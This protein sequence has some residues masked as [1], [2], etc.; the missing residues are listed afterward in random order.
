MRN[1]LKQDQ[2]GFTI[3]EVMIVLA[4]AGL[5]MLVVFMAVPAL[6]R[7]SR[8]TQAKSEAS[9]ILGAATEYISNNNGKT[10]VASTST[11]AGSDA[12]GVLA[13]SKLQNIT[14]IQIVASGSVT[15]PTAT[16]AVIRV[17]SKCT[18]TP[19]N[20]TYG[21]VVT[22]TGAAARQYTVLF[23]TESSSGNL[24]SCISS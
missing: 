4:I 13:N 14:T 16:K 8:N 24:F 19:N 11:T 18:D 9:S 1:K 3:I 17:G 7:N 6:Q 2:K 20:A 12:A 15:Q 22:T 5:I 23:L 10:L 21:N